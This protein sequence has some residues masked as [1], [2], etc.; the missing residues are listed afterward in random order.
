M[1]LLIRDFQPLENVALNFQVESLPLV[2]SFLVSGTIRNHL[3]LG[4]LNVSEVAYA[5]GYSNV[6]HFSQ[7]FKSRFGTT[8]GAYRRNS[9]G[10]IN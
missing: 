10:S 2:F 6:D 5:V 1:K 9:Q 7:S 3:R 4:L 8:P